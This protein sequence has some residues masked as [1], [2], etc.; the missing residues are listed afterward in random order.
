MMHP[1]R[2]TPAAGSALV[3]VVVM[4][5]ASVGFSFD[6]EESISPPIGPRVEVVGFDLSV[7]TGTLAYLDHERLVVVEDGPGSRTLNPDSIAY[8]MVDGPDDAI[9]RTPSPSYPARLWLTDG[10]FYSTEPVIRQGTLLWKNDLVGRI[11]TSL[12]EII[13]FSSS[14]I[15]F[16]ISSP[17]DDLVILENG[18][19]IE[20]LVDGVDRTIQ[21]EQA[22]GSV[23][24]VPLDRV[25]SFTLVNDESPSS[26]A[27]LWSMD[28]DRIAL[29]SYRYETG[30]GLIFGD[31][32]IHVP[33]LPGRVM[34]F[35]H[36][37]DRLVP[38]ADL[39][40]RTLGI[41]GRVRYHH[42]PPV[43][44]EGI[45]PLDAAP[46]LLS[47]PIRLEWDLPESNLGLIAS[48]VLPSASRRHGSVELIVSD[49]S[50]E[51]LRRVL[52]G[53]DPTCEIR[54]SI[55][56]RRLVMEL[57]ENGD[58]PLQDTVLLEQAVLLEVPD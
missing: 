29:D 15:T 11:S 51:R 37:V 16:P 13:A 43:S 28:G 3:G 27:R 9:T 44:E 21:V 14:S 30:L 5:V 25:S 42:P 18:D 52:T 47:G 53:D 24:D 39:P 31:R 19:R 40:V 6:Q 57:H 35:T 33:V 49:E 12:D 56:G 32:R 45:W 2:N 8:L 1:T 20:G 17:T 54:L 48:A 26:S 38:L 22:D 10:S 4:C 46:M 55:R 23:V 50:G 41:E 58:G 36:D 34:A 7:S